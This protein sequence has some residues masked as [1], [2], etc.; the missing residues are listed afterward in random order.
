MMRSRSVRL[1]TAAAFLALCAILSLTP[2]TT[3]EAGGDCWFCCQPD[4][5][6]QT[7]FGYHNCTLVNGDCTPSGEGCGFG[8]G[9]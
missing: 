9:P 6:S 2:A 7:R 1:F 5:C 4:L 3:A 8:G